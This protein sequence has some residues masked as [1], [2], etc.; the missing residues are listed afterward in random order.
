MAATLMPIRAV[1]ANK[2]AKAM[3]MVD[4]NDEVYL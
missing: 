4:Q 3:I 1:F 2:T